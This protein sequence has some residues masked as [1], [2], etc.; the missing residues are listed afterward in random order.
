MTSSLSLLR[1]PRVRPAGLPPSYQRRVRA[2]TRSAPCVID[3]I[4]GL[5]RLRVPLAGPRF[6]PV[7]CPNHKQLP[8]YRKHNWTDK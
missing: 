6:P 4:G 5:E 1:E 8:S 2:L 7:A 3:S